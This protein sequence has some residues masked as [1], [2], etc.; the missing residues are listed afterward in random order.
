MDLDIKYF[1]NL[2]DL[3][4]KKKTIILHSFKLFFS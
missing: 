2:T 1:Y 4:N 3:V